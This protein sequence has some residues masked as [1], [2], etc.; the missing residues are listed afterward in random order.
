MYIVHVRVPLASRSPHRTPGPTVSF[1]DD[2]AGAAQ[3][4]AQYE[5]FSQV[6]TNI[7]LPDVQPEHGRRA[8]APAAAT[9]PAEH[10]AA[11][12]AAGAARAGRGQGAEPAPRRARASRQHGAAV[13]GAA[14]ARGGEPRQAGHGGGGE[15]RP[16][17]DGA[18]AGQARHR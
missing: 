17:G 13:G 5:I 3:G 11:A 6:H 10:P 4:E 7:F 9:E 15:T 12:R 8:G 18:Q 16:Q 14:A 2:P 1:R